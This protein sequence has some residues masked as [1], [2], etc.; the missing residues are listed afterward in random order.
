MH[1][2]ETRTIAKVTMRLVPFLMVCY[3][4]TYLDRVNIS[5]AA[6]TMNKDL[7]LSATAYG[8]GATRRGF[9]G[10][11]VMG[12]LKDATGDHSAGLWVIAAC[13]AVALLRHDTRLEGVPSGVD[14]GAVPPL[15]RQT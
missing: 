13:A 10:P 14:Q 8:L 15:A 6:L 5:F 7:G 11:F 12:S 9:V 1:D 3:F 4:V 2:L